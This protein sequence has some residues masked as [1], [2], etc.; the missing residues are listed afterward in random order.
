MRSQTWLMLSK[1]LHGLAIHGAR[2]A[3]DTLHN[4][5]AYAARFR[6]TSIY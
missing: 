3:V 4:I 2:V 6:S 5:I 1:Y